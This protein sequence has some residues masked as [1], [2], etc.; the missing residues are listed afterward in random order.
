ML[1]SLAQTLETDSALETTWKIANAIYD[2]HFPERAIRL[3]E[4]QA[5][6][7]EKLRR[8]A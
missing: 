8:A 5:R 3:P 6:A 1:A 4:L 7:A 2:R